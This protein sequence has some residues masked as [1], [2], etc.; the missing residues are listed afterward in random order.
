MNIKHYILLILILFALSTNAQKQVPKNL[1][2]Y[3]VVKLHFGMALGFNRTD[4]VIY[5]SD[6][7][8]GLDSVYSVETQ[9]VPGF[10]I[11][12]VV[13]YNLN[14]YWG[15]RFLPGLNFGQRDLHYIVYDPVEEKPFE[16]VMQI[17]STYLDFPLFLQLKSERINNFRAYVIGGLSY[18]YDLS[19]QKKIKEDEK[20]KIRFNPHI[21]NYEI[22]LGTDFFLQYFK[23]A[24]E[25]RYIRGVNN[26]IKYDASQYTQSIAKMENQMFFVTFLFEGSDTDGLAF[27]KWFKR[28]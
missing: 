20:P 28:K 26:M 7:F 21:L 6:K 2:K 13:N 12:I 11:N 18:K 14:K 19:S 27:F 15:I 1:K 17:E 5:N 3:D 24:I 9:A 16:K 8:F 25:V 4:G 10:N 22:G 23:F